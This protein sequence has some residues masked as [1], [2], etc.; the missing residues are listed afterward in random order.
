MC[1]QT[2]YRLHYTLTV[3]YLTR[4]TVDYSYLPPRRTWTLHFTTRHTPSWLVTCFHPTYM[5]P[6][7]CQLDYIASYLPPRC[8]LDNTCLCVQ[9]SRSISAVLPGSTRPPPAPLYCLGPSSPVTSRS[10]SVSSTPAAA[11]PLPGSAQPPPAPPVL[12]RR[13]RRR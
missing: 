4:C 6:P 7:A 13:S 11:P 1:M 10:S 9:S 5:L 2:I 3:L 12:L 8:I